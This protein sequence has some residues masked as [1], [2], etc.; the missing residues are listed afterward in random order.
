MAA[1]SILAIILFVVLIAGGY[2]TI[3]SGRIA[4]A[5]IL[6]SGMAG[7]VCAIVGISQFNDYSYKND[8][9]GAILIGV[10]VLTMLAVGVVIKLLFPNMGTG[11]KSSEQEKE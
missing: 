8:I 1:I 4:Q 10:G 6:I 9:P 7:A 11:N 2:I 3:K 5:L